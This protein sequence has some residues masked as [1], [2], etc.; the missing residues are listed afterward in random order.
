ME[1]ER[2]GGDQPQPW[3]G[4]PCPQPLALLSW[5]CSLCPDLLMSSLKTNAKDTKQSSPCMKHWLTTPI[6][7]SH[8][9]E[10]GYTRLQELLGTG[11]FGA[12]HWSPFSHLIHPLRLM[13]PLLSGPA[14]LW[15]RQT[16]R[17]WGLCV[18]WA[19][20][21]SVWPPLE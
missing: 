3:L 5:S 20:A 12:Q 13:T 17:D 19:A 8:C 18:S 10:G 11:D 16:D 21:G 7:G 15:C 6:V 2:D 9:R 14:L 1:D 4:S